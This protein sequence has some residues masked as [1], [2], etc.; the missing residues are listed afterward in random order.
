MAALAGTSAY[1][2]VLPPDLRKGDLDARLGGDAREHADPELPRPVPRALPE[3]HD[4]VLPV[5]DLSDYIQSGGHDQAPPPGP[6]HM[7][8]AL[9]RTAKPLIK[10][11]ALPGPLQVGGCVLEPDGVPAGP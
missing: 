1:V 11:P 5:F 7:R 10:S 4:A 2:S 9:C 6:K 8:P 3:D